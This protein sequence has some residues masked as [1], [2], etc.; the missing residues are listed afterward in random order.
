M[1]GVAASGGARDP[2]G[3]HREPLP[4]DRGGGARA[5]SGA[6]PRLKAAEASRP[7]PPAAGALPTEHRLPRGLGAARRPAVPLLAVLVLLAAGSTLQGGGPG[8]G[9]VP[10]A[11]PY[12]PPAPWAA[13]HMAATLL[14]GSAFA[15]SHQDGG[16][17]AAGIPEK[18]DEGFYEE[19]QAL[20]ESGRG[21]QTRSSALSHYDVVVVVVTHDELGNDISSR[22]K[23][24]VAASLAEAGAR[25]IF[26]AETLP[27]VSASVPVGSIIPLS[28]QGDVYRLGN[29][30][31]Q[32]HASMDT[33]RSTIN[34]TAASLGGADGGG[35]TVAVIDNN[36]INHPLLN[37]RTT[38]VSCG[39]GPC[40][41]L[42]DPSTVQS[43]NTGSHGNL[44]GSII[45]AT[46]LDAH[47]GIAPGVDLISLTNLDLDSDESG[48]NVS[49]GSFYRSLDWAI[50]NGAAVVNISLG[51]G[52]CST[53]GQ[54]STFHLILNDAVTKGL[55]VAISAGNT[56]KHENNTAAFGSIQRPACYENAVAVG[57]INDRQPGTP[58]AYQSTG[59]GPALYNGANPIL[60]PDIVAPASAVMVPGSYQENN[61]AAAQ[62]GTSFA[63]PQVAA[64]AAILLGQD[65]TMNP[66]ET[67]AALLLG[68]N[69]TGPVP[70]TS[71]QYERDDASD[72]C[73][74]ARQPS[75][76]AVANGPNSL[77]IL[78]NAGFGILDV[79]QSLHYAREGGHVLSGSVADDDTR[80]YRF[81]VTDTSDPI[82]VILTWNDPVQIVHYADDAV[83]HIS[84]PAPDLD[85]VVNCPG[86]DPIPAD[87][88][89]Q[90]NEFAVFTA[91]RAGACTVTVEARSGH[92]EYALASTE[93]F[94]ESALSVESVTSQTDD[95]AYA[96]GDVVDVRVRLS[97]PAELDPAR[98]AQGAAGS[99]G[100]EFRG[101]SNVRWV[102]ASSIGDSVYALVAGHFTGLQIIDMT[103]PG[104][105]RA[106]A[107]VPASPEINLNKTQS[108]AAA[109]I[110]DSVYALAANANSGLQIIDITD[111][112][113]PEASGFAGLGEGAYR[114][115]GARHVSV[116]SIGGSHYALV[117]SDEGGQ[118]GVQI[119]DITDPDS[120]RAASFAATGGGYEFTNPIFTAA[121]TINGHH[122]A[123]AASWL[124]NVL[125]IINITDPESPA[126][127]T[128]LRHGGAANIR[129]THAVDTIQ[130]GGSH[131]ALVASTASG[132]QIL[133]ITDP[134]DPRPVAHVA[135]G[136]DYRLDGARSVEAVQ[137]D[138]SYYALLAAQNSNSLQIVDIT[139]PASPAA[140]AFVERK[141]GVFDQMRS[142]HQV[143]AV[144]VGG[145]HYALVASHGSDGLQVIDIT[146]PAAP[147]NPL[148]PSLALDVGAEPRGAAYDGFDGDRTMTFRY[149]VAAGDQTDDLGYADTGAL[150]LK[151]SVLRAAGND[152]PAGPLI[153]PVPGEANSLSANK[154]IRLNPP[155]D[156]AA[157]VTTWRTTT[158]ADTITLPVSGSGITVDWGDGTPDSAGVSGP[159]NHTYA[160][161]GTYTVTVS[162]GL[163]RF[164]LDNHSDAPL[165]SSIGQWGDIQWTSMAGAFWGASNMTYTATDAP[166]LS[167]VANMSSMFRGASSFNGD[168]SSWNVSQVADMS[169]MFYDTTAFNQPLNDWDV[170]RV[171]DMS[172]M[173]S[174]TG[175][176]NQ[177]LNG[178][179]VSQV[180]DMS[181]MF[182]DTTAFNQPL[183]DWDVSRVT[184]MSYMFLGTTSFNQP[185]DTWDVSRVTDMSQ[186]FRQS[187]FNQPLDNWDVSAV[188]NMTR[189]FQNN[190]VFNQ[191][192]SSWNVSQVTDM[193]RTFYLTDA[194]NQPLDN[195]DVSQVTD[196]Y[197][198]FSEADAFNQ[199]ISS[200]NV[201]QVT[202]MRVMFSE[203]DAFNQDISSWD[204]SQVTAMTSMFRGASSFSQNLGPWYVTPDGATVPR[205]TVPGVVTALA[206]QNAALDGHSPDY[207]IGTGGDSALFE[208][209]DANR[210]NMTD[211][212]AKSSYTVNVTAPGGD[213]GDNNHRLLT[214]TLTV[215]PP[216]ADAGNDRTV[217]PGAAVTLD[218]S[219]S[220]DIDGTTY[221]WTQ[222]SGTPTVL[223]ANSDGAAP[224]FTAP[225]VTSPVDLVF[226][227]E[228]ARAGSVTVTDAVTV[229]VDPGAFVT[230]WSPTTSD[231][232]VTLP[233]AGT[234]MTIDWGDGSPNETGVSSHKDH[235]YDATGTYTV[236]V[237]GGLERFHLANHDDAPNLASIDRW[238]DASW[239]SMEEAFQGATTMA[240]NAA[241]VPDLSGVADMS[242]MFSG[243]SSFNGDISSWDV[244]QVT[245]MA[246]MFQDA[247]SFNQPLNDWDVSRVTSM[248]VMFNGASSF[249]QPLNDWDVSRVTSMSIMFRDASSFNDDISSWN[250]SQV[251]D[252]AGMFQDAS[253]FNQPLNDWDVSRVTSMAV[254]FNGASSFNQPLND[255]DVSRVT[256]MSIMF[257]DASSFNDDISSW[258]VSQVTAMASMF[259]GSSFNQPLASWDVSRVT[260]MYSMFRDASAFNGDISSWDVSQV[261]DMAEMFRGASSFNGD[262]SSWNVSSVTDMSDMFRDANAFDR[263]L[264]NWY[265]VL[266]DT[267][268]SS[269]DESLAIRA[270]NAW[271]DGQNPAYLV[272]DG[273]FVVTGDAMLGV[274]RDD[275]PPGGVHPLTVTAS[276]A[277]LFGTDNSRTVRIDVNTNSPPTVDAGTPQ[278]VSEGST[279]SLDGTADDQDA[280][281]TL[282]YEW[283]HN[284]TL[285][286]TLDDGE[287]LDTTFTA[288]NVAE[289]TPVQFTLTVS[290]GTA[291][292]SD[293][294][295]VTITD[296]ANTPPTVDAGDDQTVTEGSTVTLDGDATDADTEDTPTYR[297]SHNSTL[298]ITLDDGE[299]LDTTFTAPNVAEDT[300]IEFTLTVMD[301]T[302]TVSDTVI[303]T[304]T[305]S[306]NT[307]PTV[308]AGTPQTVSEGS[309]V[310]L[311]GTADDQDAEDTL[312]YEW[313]HNSTL[314]IPISSD[315]SLDTTFTA[316]NVAEDTPVQFTLTVSDGTATV[317]DTVIITITDS[318]NTPPTVDAGDD[319]TVTEGSTVTLDGDATDADTEDTP[320]Y[321]W[322]HNS[323]LTITLDDGEALDTTFTAPNVAE[324]TPIEFTLTVMDGTATVSDTVLVTITDSANTPPTVDAGDDQTVSEGSTV[325]LDGTADDQDAEDTLA[326][327]WTHNSTLTIPISSDTS[328]DTTFTAPNV[329]EDTPIEFTLTVMDGT[330]TVSDTVLVTI[331]DSANTPPTVDAG[332]DQ[333]VTEGSTVTLD[334]DATDADTEDTPTY[335]WSHNST[336]TI[337]LDDGEALDT[338]FTAPNV[339]EDTPIEFTLTVMDGTATVSDTV[340]I[341]ITDSANT[342]PTVDAGDDQT[343][344]EGSTVTLDGDATDADTE[345]TP[346]YRWSHNSTLTITLDDGEALDTTFTAP[347][348]AED[349][350]IE[351]TLTVMDGTA[352]VSDTVIITI[353]DSA[354]TPPTVDAGDDQTVTEGST[355][356]LDG[357]ATDADTEDTPTYR[358]SHNS[359]LTI[360]LDDGEAL[361]TTFTAPNV[362]ED[363]PI[364]F[365]LTVMDGT[366]TVSD[367][368][369]ITITDSANTPPTVDAG[370]DQTVTEGS[371]VTL[372]GDATDADTEDTP[373]YRWSHNSTLTITLDDGEALDTTFTAPNVAEDTPIEFTLTV[374]DG[375]ATVSDTVLVTITDSA[376]TP[377]TVD[378]GDDQTVSEGSTVSLDGTADDQD[379]EDTLAYEWTHNSTLTIPIS[380]DTS[381]DTT[382]TAPNVAEDTPIEFTLTVMDDT[383]TVSDTVIITI[384]DSANTP[385]TVDAG[386]DQTVSEGS[387]VSLD[388]TA[389]DQDAEDTLAYEWT[390][391]S[392]LTIPISSDTSLDTTFTA[393]NVAEDTPIEFTLTV[394]DG[395]ATVSDTVIITITDSANTPPTVDAGTP[396]TVSEGSTV[397]LDGTADDQD[398]EDTLAYEWTHNS[399]L[400]I[401]ISSDTSLDTTFTAP[402]V[403]EDTPIEFT[404]TV[405]DGTATVSD[406]VIITI[407][408]T[409]ADTESF[410]ITWE[411][412][413]PGQRITLPVAGSDM[414]I[415][416][417]DGQT[418]TGISG[419]RN[420]TYAV[421]GTYAVSVSGGL[422]R[423][424]LDDHAGAPLLASIDQ[425]GDTQWTSMEGAFR[426]AS[427]MA[428]GA[429]DIPDLSGVTDMSD[430]FNG[431]SSFNGD[432]S[433]WNVSQVTDMTGM[434]EG[435]ASFSQN[436]G[437]WYVVLD[438][439]EISS[440]SET[441][442]IR[443][444]NA[445]LDGHN[446]EYATASPGFEITGDRLGLGADPPDT[447]IRPVTVTAA[448]DI[449]GTG[450]SRHL[451]IRVSTQSNGAPTVDAGPDQVAV[452]GARVTLSG[453]ATDPDGDTLT[454]SWTHNGG[455]LGIT[456]SGA[457]SQTATF[458]APQVADGRVHITFTL[459]VSD[460][461]SY[462]SDTVAVIIW[463]RPVQHQGDTRQSQDNTGPSITLPGGSYVQI[464]RGG[465]YDPPTCHDAEDGAITDI[466]SAGAV[467]TGTPGTYRVTYTCTDSG[468]LSDTASQAVVVH[469]YRATLTIN[470]PNPAVLDVGDGWSDPG[471][472]CAFPDGS[473]RPAAVSRNSVDTSRPG[474]YLVSYTCSDPSGEILAAE[475]RRVIVRDAGDDHAPVIH[476]P[477]PMTVTVGQTWVD[478]GITCTDDLDPDPDVRVV[479]TDLDVSRPGE[480][481]VFYTCTDA[482]GNQATAVRTVTVVPG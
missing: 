86:M 399:T 117:S 355:V 248:A 186:M 414:T 66:A 421:A 172:F 151:S 460:G 39:V 69:W 113:V 386:D 295:L 100:R 428:Y 311:D 447:G 7:F 229:R 11:V 179:D 155:P 449:F 339:A 260:S 446:P 406:T 393:P 350:P 479:A 173:L 465:S 162:G 57:G 404:L 313:T 92:G 189:M 137:V 377:P 368:V 275:L 165:L 93:P 397:S 8:D 427:S 294:V 51:F 101:L 309:T 239:T 265:V 153:L 276:G 163:E 43:I 118:K 180:T 301:G 473:S 59:R 53:L 29:G 251:T 9:A 327:E 279:V 299:A 58:V 409:D 383:A 168:I 193:S 450:N 47:N 15:D 154:D 191:D 232:S 369:I 401:P 316:P 54:P 140:V 277:N 77:E 425:W 443:A 98:V 84:T 115:S 434:F 196:M 320:T 385:P 49:T 367:T 312:A 375:T 38:H 266:D 325:S 462:A 240:Y 256:S 318:A 257:R 24:D 89:H 26:V 298:T 50:T 36:I 158:A 200:W 360:T 263:N 212:Q 326:Y 456:L 246:G 296:S 249:N 166:D 80:T 147:S 400:T 121:T 170:S 340:I 411:T 122:Y 22:T 17:P 149:A 130:M 332:D 194:F 354:N 431:A 178:W 110:G 335:R 410:I 403:A 228:V 56:G 226:T 474:T 358:W 448:G 441:L 6:W 302:A 315:T 245:D 433:S 331:T 2:A 127:V 144:Q 148:L 307:P 396:Q 310:S 304:I 227:L 314:T 413:S 19:V 78:N 220:T 271:L 347:N 280:E 442:A 463:D 70:C 34:A 430:M 68:A 94:V 217:A 250:V 20:A 464:V 136:G 378:A 216:I 30:Q 237:S 97:G 469:P 351:F 125:Q 88:R 5:A 133:N 199:D 102:A 104:G 371:T 333:T 174:L 195:W 90:H 145:S 270:Q 349:T 10:D 218:G 3:G 422:E 461:V 274:N 111:P 471:A 213:F 82:K 87:S 415:H 278:T 105:P 143:A 169:F 338:T 305:D 438:D 4:H 286:I 254:M 76:L 356:T 259:R 72:N 109:R 398:A 470:P 352:T 210:L 468:G 476:P 31:I 452:E 42:D 454:W 164:H 269:A 25:H 282:A 344:T 138:G 73:S 52:A 432:I 238:G 293:T 366:A 23:A 106:T 408:D 32:A 13:P 214:I 27:F 319:Q 321:R 61:T 33:A 346:T 453:T 439:T 183:N 16:K 45:A 290:D 119:I 135:H 457:A 175:A 334:G 328:L 236:T 376:N 181:F 475:A 387:T 215:P 74:W 324:D 150:D 303:I 389:D 420:H 21:T 187:K 71:V 380:S 477:T 96:T 253:S 337:T 459:A 264:G 445:F 247:S 83:T 348:V 128:H 208:V 224:S 440:A 182:Y 221:A 157:F 132:L 156:T 281:D 139:D 330:A 123:L 466:A 185:L 373:T 306:A 114:F 359:T 233:V 67:R 381:L 60:K 241:D 472:A 419:A 372:D 108:L 222:T 161:P 44:V 323:T 418:D 112:A 412:S 95:G 204:V 91:D 211:V 103:D 357:D 167:G 283:T 192:I 272:D 242:E 363:T 455:D 417:G 184:D 124:D 120:P 255:W 207:D 329:A 384:T 480:Y 197:S 131:Y 244:S 202:D 126:P 288:P 407:T 478:P 394:M 152:R 467:N 177:P 390:H 209:V 142:P 424:H 267:A 289:D 231:L 273:R 382:F 46:G 370:D 107:Y 99:D 198:M 317:S 79:G 392:T 435:A 129:G 225:E 40:S 134:A 353:T 188:T 341:T 423:F 345:D 287:A 405:M 37:H 262:I 205:T 203:A 285:T 230:A 361:D 365:T 364:E 176:F 388:G 391:N 159:T 48:I 146:A 291:T 395:T 379:A 362:A 41:V 402:N 28:L 451:E 297:W 75:D 63:A 55:F 261:A 336:L 62:Y 444:Q 64:A 252:M 243:A 426:G 141:D 322:S 65:E 268:I 116:A 206:A 201:S 429:T 234:G 300:P 12:N 160:T 481:R 35:V 343:V 342:P 416:W 1:L 258:N 458:T 308:D 436:L 284:S 81:E 171:A 235:A 219:G 482:A 223:I 437:N 190:Q 18:F 14:P 292:V 374:M 85:F